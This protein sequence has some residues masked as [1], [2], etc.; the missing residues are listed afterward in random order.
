MQCK[1]LVVHLTEIRM[2]IRW[3]YP[4][5]EF[6]ITDLVFDAKSEMFKKKNRYILKLN[7]IWF[8]TLDNIKECR[9]FLLLTHTY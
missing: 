1:N 6:I 3:A 9:F 7:L 4:S 2:L 5:V 8:W